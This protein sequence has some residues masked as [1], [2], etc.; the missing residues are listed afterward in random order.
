MITTN[1]VTTSKQLASYWARTMETAPHNQFIGSHSCFIT[2]GKNCC[3]KFWFHNAL[4]GLLRRFKVT[5]DRL[6]VQ[7]KPTYNG[8]GWELKNF[9]PSKQK[10]FAFQ[11]PS[12][13]DDVLAFLL[14][15]TVLDQRHLRM[16][17]WNMAF[18]ALARDRLSVISYK[19]G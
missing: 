1:S 16:I 9:R 15:E 17:S 13:I 10:G 14:Y 7:S 18:E 19:W 5:A 6:D 2:L 3:S 12:S 11:T 4:H 8:R